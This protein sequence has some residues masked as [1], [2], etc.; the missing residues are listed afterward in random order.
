MH[1][2]QLL[3][4]EKALQKLC[5]EKDELRAK[6]DDQSRECVHL[7]Q[8][9]ERLE[10]DLALSHEKLHTLHLEVHLFLF[11]SACVCVCMYARVKEISCWLPNMYFK[12]V[13][14]VKVRS[15]DQLILQLRA[16]MKSSQ[17]KQ[18]KRL[19]QVE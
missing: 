9:Q 14:C 5:E 7:K 15:R 4:R 11:L 10:A 18:Q 19:E 17:Q 13:F 6:M 3:Q 1:I 16:E 2:S 12:F 8:T